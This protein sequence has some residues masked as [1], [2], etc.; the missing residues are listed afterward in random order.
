M[1]LRVL[2]LTSGEEIVGELVS[3]NTEYFVLKTTFALLVRG[4]EANGGLAWGFAPWGL[5]SEGDKPIRST[6][7]ITA[8]L[9]TQDV[10]DAYTQATTGLV[11]PSHQLITG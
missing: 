4:R 2:K 3:E 6:H 8:G 11:T 1:E 9:P 10:I 7:V 5:F